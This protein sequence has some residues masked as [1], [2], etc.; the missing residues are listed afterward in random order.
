MELGDIAFHNTYTLFNHFTKHNKNTDN[1]L[2]KEAMVNILN[3][4]GVNPNF[5][6]KPDFVG[7]RDRGIKFKVVS[8]TKEGNLICNKMIRTDIKKEIPAPL[9]CGTEKITFT[10]EKSDD[11]PVTLVLDLEAGRGELSWSWI[12]DMNKFY[13]EKDPEGFQF[14]EYK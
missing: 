14:T 5:P 6:S 8:M 9:L 12:Y 2:L 11:E 4:L 7:C 13:K 10:L 3:E 1:S